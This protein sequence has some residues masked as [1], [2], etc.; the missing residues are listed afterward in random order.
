MLFIRNNCSAF[1]E[2]PQ[3]EIL[4]KETKSF[5]CRFNFMWTKARFYY[6]KV[7]INYKQTKPSLWGYM[8]AALFHDASRWR[9]WGSKQVF[10][11]TV[12]VTGG[13][14][15]CWWS[16]IGNLHVLVINWVVAG[17]NMMEACMYKRN[18][19]IYNNRCYQ[20]LD[21][22]AMDSTFDNERSIE[23]K[24]QLPWVASVLAGCRVITTQCF[25]S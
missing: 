13:L 11:F 24:H 8:I 5:V 6:S 14:K 21:T 10:A 19:C 22:D 3:G 18:E 12:L 7:R 4:V 15:A 17:F 16:F 23:L 20:Q 2:N 1:V 25:M 9:I